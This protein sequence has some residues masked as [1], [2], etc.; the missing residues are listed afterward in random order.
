MQSWPF[1]LCGS[2][3]P[4]AQARK[5]G[6]NLPRRCVEIVDVVER[7]K[8]PLRDRLKSPLYRLDNIEKTNAPVEERVNR[9]LVRRVQHGGTAAAAYQR[10]ASDPQ[11]RETALV[12]RLESDAADSCQIEPLGRRFDAARHPAR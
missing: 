6:G 11:S 1:R 7:F 2:A 12:G 10:L 4:V 9:R 3:H 5:S 8:L